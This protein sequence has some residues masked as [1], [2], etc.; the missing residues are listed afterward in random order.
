MK[1]SKAEY[2]QNKF[3]AGLQIV[4]EEDGEL[5][6]MGTEDQW[7][8]DEQFENEANNIKM[9]ELEEVAKF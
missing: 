3:R 6:W 9:A 1:I 7:R 5:L 2:L 8:L 4:G